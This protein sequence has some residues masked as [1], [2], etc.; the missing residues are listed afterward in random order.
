MPEHN[1]Q[2]LLLLYRSTGNSAAKLLTI[3]TIDLTGQGASVG[4]SE[5]VSKILS[6]LP[7]KSFIGNKYISYIKK[8]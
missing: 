3:C 2:C 6:H 4:I 8:F 5:F 7:V 1:Q